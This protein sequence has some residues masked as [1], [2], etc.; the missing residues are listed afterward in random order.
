MQ[1]LSFIFNMDKEKEILLKRLGNNIQKLRKEKGLTQVEL[2]SAV[3]KDQ[4]SIQRLEVGNINP[5]FYY[6]YEIA[7]GLGVD[8][9]ELIDL[10][11]N[12]NYK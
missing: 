9:K 3:N 6:L 8:I 1:N 2:A 5:S 10:S 4:Q 7:K 11:E 12:N